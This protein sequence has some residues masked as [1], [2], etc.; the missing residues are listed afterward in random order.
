MMLGG[1]PVAPSNVYDV[2]SAVTIRHECLVPLCFASHGLPPRNVK[3]V[4]CVA[5]IKRMNIFVVLCI[6]CSTE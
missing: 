3:D 1:A 4:S 6:L 2:S 5:I